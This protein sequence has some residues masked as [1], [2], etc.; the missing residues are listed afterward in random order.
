MT[1]FKHAIIFMG[2]GALATTVVLK[3]TNDSCVNDLMKKE[4]KI[5]QNLKEKFMC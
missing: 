5:M 1:K 4:K 3:M 2:L